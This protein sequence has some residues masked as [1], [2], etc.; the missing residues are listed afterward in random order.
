MSS[1]CDWKYD[2]DEMADYWEAACGGVLRVVICD[3]A[4]ES[5]E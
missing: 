4:S 5:V 3:D 1:A 2:G